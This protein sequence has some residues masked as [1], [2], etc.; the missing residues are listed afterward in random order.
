[1]TAEFRMEFQQFIVRCTE[2]YLIRYA[3]KGLYKRALKELEKG[4]AVQY[5]LAEN[6][7]RCTLEDGTEC[8]LTDTLA[9]CQCSCPAETVCKHVLISIL[10]YREHQV[11]D[12]AGAEPVASADFSWLLKL[13]LAQLLKSFT[14]LVVAEVR[15]RLKFAGEVE[16]REDSLLTVKLLQYNAEVSF[17]EER[18]PGK[19]LC[20]LKQREGELCK[21]EALL[22]YRAQQGINDAP[23]LDGLTETKSISPEFL[24]ECA[25][26]LS[27]ILRTGLARLPQTFAARLE[28]M[29]VS[30]H[31]EALPN[32]E[33]ALRGIQGE[34]ELFFAR[35]V[36]F[37]MTA[38]LDRLSELGLMIE[39]LAQPLAAEQQ[40]QLVGSFRSQYYT[41]PKLRL[42]ALG[43]DAWETR[44]A[45]RGITYYFF[46]LEDQAIY[47]YT[48]TRPVYYEGAEFNFSKQYAAYSPWLPG[49]SMKQLSREQLE[50][51]GVKVNGERRLSTAEGARLELVPRM[52]VEELD[53]GTLVPGSSQQERLQAETALFSGGKEQ[54]AIL[55]VARITETRFDPSSQQLVLTAELEA[56]EP[57]ELTL[58]FEQDWAKAVNRLEQHAGL[59]LADPFLAL[60][61]LE[62]SRIQ[63]VSFLKG[64]QLIS[65]KLD[66]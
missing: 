32:I 47:T 20:S 17:T 56:G 23:E 34:L 52:R 30:A 33:R 9:Q 2:D 22:R 27:S 19:A 12:S 26:L 3:N 66:L 50:F 18:D 40:E 63:P 42:Y 59:K 37:S 54:L 60:V 57:L 41:V 15:F 11:A 53:F 31:S 16:I 8:K 24:K 7:V 1:M 45:Y 4:A 44:S 35:H 61:R 36:R 62:G 29:A 64:Q 46:G 39:A 43:A 25:S 21:L 58:P 6:E 28:T 14:P 51:S 10:Y 5:D 49:I 38:F 55:P 13:P 65:L 48:D